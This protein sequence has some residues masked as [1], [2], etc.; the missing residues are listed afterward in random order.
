MLSRRIGTRFPT[1]VAAGMLLATFLLP[2]AVAAH[3]SSPSIAPR[4]PATDLAPA[5]DRDGQ[6]MGGPRVSRTID[7]REWAMVSDLAAGEAPRF[8]PVTAISPNAAGPWFALGSNGAGNGAV[9][10]T[11]YAV[12]VSGTDVYVGGAFTDVAGIPTADHVAKW[13]GSAWSALG[14]NGAGNGAISGPVHAFAIAGSDVYVGGN[15]MNAAGIPEADDIAKW[16]GIAWSA[17][18]SDGTGDGAIY[19]CDVAA[20]A[21]SGTDLYVGGN[22]ILDTVSASGLNI[23]KWSGSAWSALGSG[24]DLN[25]PV[26][27]LAVLGGNLF[28]G[29]GF[30]DAAGIQAADYIVGYTVSVGS[31]FALGSNGAG[32]G[33][34]SGVV[35]SLAVSSGSLFVGG[36]FINAAGIATADY[37][38]RWA[39]NTWSALGS[40]GS[41]I[42][43][44]NFPVRSLLVSGS[45][46][47]VGGEFSNAAGLPAADY[48]AKWSASAWSAL[49]ENGVANGALNNPALALA[50]SST[51]LYV[52]GGFWDVAGIPTA[53]YV[54][55]WRFEAPPPPPPAG[56]TFVPIDPVRLLD[57]R[58]NLGLAGRFTASTP[59]LLTV[60][61]RLGIPSQAVAITANLTVVGQ[62]QAGY[63]SVTPTLDSNPSTSA[64]NFPLGD[65]RANNI[66]SPLS[67]GKLSIV[68]KAG[69]EKKTHVLLDVTG[70]F[71]ENNT[72]E[73]YKPVTP[74]RLLDTRFGNGLTGPFFAHIV[75]DFDVA[76]RD[77][78]P[79]NAK[80]VTG[81][82]TVFG[83]TAA[84]YVT[85]GPTLADN[86]STSTINFPLGDT[87]ANGITV[88][89]AADG[90]LDAIYVA[91][92]GK[93][94]HLI[95]DVTGYYLQD[96]TGSKFYPLDPGR[97][98]DTRFG[99][100]LSGTFKNSVARTL[101]IRGNV[102]VPTPAIAV[103]GNLT[104]VGQTWQGYVSM[105]KTPTNLP[106]TSTLNFPIGDVRANGVTG[107]LS[108]TGTVGLVYKADPNKTTNLILDI[109]G[110]FRP[111][112]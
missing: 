36:S 6:L 112:T 59:R 41:G 80:A 98:L 3:R 13:N 26:D 20:L 109:T 23:A 34:L 74:V 62:Q 39:A 101:T 53:D 107:P 32:G 81:N 9:T 76:G 104:V 12:A 42:G 89:L 95:F 50:A 84:G 14:S 97:V 65:D 22:I 37:I 75:R 27:A 51:N 5:L 69:A 78:I 91:P 10:S 49:G 17:L 15:F 2:T 60:A 25:S 28:I 99:V 57:T 7:I 77:G 85:L 83:Q 102:G 19:C 79:D 73:T 48:I 18:G 52:G 55:R 72:G 35:T 16:N 88:R 29:G 56:T 63:L 1:A 64:L 94:A 38:A 92:L 43:A 90:H 40:S 106:A 4:E 47:Y 45:D 100:G 30:T 24:M 71:M 105:T 111:L 54:A 11:V 21:F 58:T 103:T 68:Y 33:A 110:V 70:Y 31:W 82:L 67:S 93:L 8:A 66:T 61:G 44:L 87:R 86:P 46:L 108:G 96:L